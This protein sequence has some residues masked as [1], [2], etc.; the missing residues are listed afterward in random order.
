MA[1][2]FQKL[3]N[4]ENSD[5]KHNPLK[6]PD[7]LIQLSGYGTI[8]ADVKNQ[9]VFRNSNNDKEESLT[10]SEVEIK[11]A[12]NFQAEFALKWW[13]VFYYEGAWLF[14]NLQ[15]VNQFTKKENHSF[16][17]KGKVF[18]SIPVSSFLTHAF[19]IFDV[20]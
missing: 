7:F 5:L 6:R 1:K 10:L 4:D 8:V 18:Y 11:K 15:K 12:S 3:S 14:T 19:G 17:S 9:T 20:V 16:S 13:W 2:A